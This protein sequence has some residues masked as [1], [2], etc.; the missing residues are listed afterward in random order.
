M[1][2]LCEEAL[3]HETTAIDRVYEV[4]RSLGVG[5]FRGGPHGAVTSVGDTVPVFLGLGAEKTR[6]RSDLE[7]ELNLVF[8]ARDVV[9]EVF[10]HL[11]WHVEGGG[12]PEVDL[13]FVVLAHGLN[14]NFN[15]NAIS[16]C[17]N[18]LEGIGGLLADNEWWDVDRVTWAVIWHNEYFRVFDSRVSDEGYISASLLNV[19]NFLDECAIPPIEQDDGHLEWHPVK[20]ERFLCLMLEHIW[21]ERTASFFVRQRDKNLAKLY[22][23]ENVKQR[24]YGLTIDDP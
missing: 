23:M 2:A 9:T 21:S 11:D 22:R 16:L 8:E 18:L 6:F 24:W 15:D 20:I 17:I 10:Q 1:Y 12:I 5:V 19:A 14:L 13:C 4:K 7:V 3:L